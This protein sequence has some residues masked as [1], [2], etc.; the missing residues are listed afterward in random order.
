MKKNLIA[1]LLPLLVASSLCAQKT[2]KQEKFGISGKFGISLFDGDIE[3]NNSLLPQSEL[4]FAAGLSAGYYFIPQ[5]GL[6]AEYMYL[7]YRANL[8][9][10]KFSGVTQSAI[11]YLSVNVLNI[12]KNG[13]NQ[14]W[15]IYI[16]PGIGLSFYDSKS[17]LNPYGEPKQVSDMS[18]TYPVEFSFEYSFTNYFAIL[19]NAQYRFY[20][21]DNFEAMRDLQGNSED[22]LYVSTISLKYKFHKKPK[23][24]FPRSFCR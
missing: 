24:S 12:F 20:D 4:K 15:N 21:K 2:I 8:S 7:P 13:R 18:M 22:G 11:L 19:W 17:T 16:N 10:L 23:R 1:L 9:G 6:I 3:K 5:L 14:R